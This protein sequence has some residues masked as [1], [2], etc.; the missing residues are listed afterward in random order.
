MGSLQLKSVH[1]RYGA[2]EVLKDINLEVNDGEFI[3][4]VG[5]SGCGKSTLLRSI[6]GLEDVSAG[7]VLINGEDVTVTP[8][9]RRGIAWCSSLMRFIR[10]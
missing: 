6:A 7:Q 8:P 3:I 10:I 4:F 1:K 9:S 5:P 2:Q